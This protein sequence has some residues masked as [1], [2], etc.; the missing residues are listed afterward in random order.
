MKKTYKFHFILNYLQYI[1]N[2]PHISVKT[3]YTTISFKW[4]ITV[5]IPTTK[6]LASLLYIITLLL[7]VATR[8]I[9]LMYYHIVAIYNKLIIIVDRDIETSTVLYIF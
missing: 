7:L 1:I 4:V 5:V 2:N 3:K 9:Y 6:I 8:V